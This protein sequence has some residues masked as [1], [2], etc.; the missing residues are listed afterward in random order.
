MASL[1]EN[2]C[3]ICDKVLGGLQLISR[4]KILKATY[5]GKLINLT[6]TSVSAGLG[7]RHGT[8]GLY[9][10]DDLVSSG[11]HLSA[12]HA[13]CRGCNLRITGTKIQVTQDTGHTL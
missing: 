3:D 11:H 6:S 2:T 5:E 13:Q 4:M 7:E 9:C 10:E 8:G 12:G 1:L